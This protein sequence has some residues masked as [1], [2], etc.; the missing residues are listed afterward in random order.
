MERDR[1]TYLLRKARGA[2]EGDDFRDTDV[3]ITINILEQ[4]RGVEGHTVWTKY[5]LYPS[6]CSGEV[7]KGSIAGAAGAAGVAL[8]HQKKKEKNTLVASR[9]EG[10]KERERQ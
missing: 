4:W 10:E 1:A 5:C 9:G 8:E 6:L 2:Q 7:M 3:S